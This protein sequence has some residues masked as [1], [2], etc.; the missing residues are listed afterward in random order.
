MGPGQLSINSL[1]GKIANILLAF[2]PDNIN[3][4]DAKSDL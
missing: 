4:D 1:A 2:D 3:E